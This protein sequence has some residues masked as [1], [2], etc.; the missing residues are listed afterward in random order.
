MPHTVCRFS[1]RFSKITFSQTLH[2]TMGPKYLQSRI[3]FF[4]PL[5]FDF[6]MGALSCL[7]C[8]VTKTNLQDW[9]PAS[10]IFTN[11]EFR[12]YKTF[13]QS[14]QYKNAN[15]ADCFTKKSHLETPFKQQRKFH[16]NNN[17]RKHVVSSSQH[18]K[19]RWPRCDDTVYAFFSEITFFW[20]FWRS[21]RKADLR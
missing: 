19:L 9:Y 2:L 17:S 11:L 6:Q 20:L 1:L 14:K 8:D 10:D 13:H 3:C 18:H 15:I 21:V 4:C 16:Q 5:L 7:H 12:I